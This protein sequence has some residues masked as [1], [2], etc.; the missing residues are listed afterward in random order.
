M[1]PVNILMVDDQ[2]AK[3]LAYEAMLADLGENLIKA[4]SAREAL[5]CLL[6]T[7][8]AAVLMDVSMPDVD[9]F[10]LAKLI[11]EHPRCERTAIIF[12]SA[13]HMSEE[14]IVR[15][16]ATGAVD[17]V[18][19]P[20]IP[21]ILRAKIK[22]F[23][24]LHRK[25]D[26]LKRLN[27]ELEARVRRRT[28]DLEAS[29]ARLKESETLFRR[30]GEM[31]A[32]TDRRKD[33]FLALLAHEL[34]NPLAP[35]RSAVELLQHSKNQP[36]EVERLRSMIDRQVTHL[37]HLVDD[38]L[39]AG[40]ITRG[41]LVL[42]RSPVDLCALIGE[43]VEAIRSPRGGELCAHEFVVQVPPGPIMVDADSVRL[44]QIVFN[45]VSNAIKFTPRGG[46]I[47]L[48]VSCGGG[49]AEI[50]VRDNGRGMNAD[51][52]AHAF[53]MFYQGSRAS[54]G[55][56]AGGLGLGLTLVKQLVEMHGGTVEVASDGPGCGSEFVV[57]LPLA[58]ASEQ[59]VAAENAQA[60]PGDTAAPAQGCRILIADD[61][62]DA[63]D[64]LARLLEM[65]GNEV[66][67][68]YDGDAAVAA[69]ERFDP[70]IALLDIGMPGR[71]GYA[72]ARDIR[73]AE[74]GRRVTLVAMTGWGQAEDKRRA[75]DAGFDAHMVKPV[76]IDTLMQ[77]LSELKSKIDPRPAT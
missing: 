45:L 30:Q 64:A 2:P 26:E 23:V 52:L 7:D 18:A 13:I 15:G 31:L 10:T 70:E 46:K 65:L 12:V 6:S 5:A 4:T 11:R 28:D 39:D 74:N 48:T 35:I 72:A 61:N 36:V 29:L 62:R 59:P 60:K 71:D 56:G 37:V 69:A 76:S 17:Y 21:E 57:S 38:L 8:V 55:D 43:A 54:D 20:V 66:E 34:R 19:V 16:Y 1:G 42:D 3:L 32:E 49:R 40:R 50:A 33:E 67:T 9:G 51:D 41:K 27:N 14:D 25:T 77:T 24:E 22:I 53:D 75:I 44:T 63:V 73:A 68:A 58:A 47:A